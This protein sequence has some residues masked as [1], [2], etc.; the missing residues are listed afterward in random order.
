MISVDIADAEVRLEEL[1]E[2]IEDGR[3]TEVVI[4][5]DGQ[6]V[7]RLVPIATK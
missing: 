5:R 2:A 4:F 1:V 3:E 6:A 7:A